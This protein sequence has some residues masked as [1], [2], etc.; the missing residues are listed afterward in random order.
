MVEQS[1]RSLPDA[2]QGRLIGHEFGHALTLG[3]GNGRDDTNDNKVDSLCDS[4]SESDAS[5]HA[6][7]NPKTVMTISRCYAQNETRSTHLE[8]IQ[9]ARAKAAA[10]KI[11]NMV[12]PPDPVPG[13]VISDSRGDAVSDVTQ[14]GLDLVSVTLAQ[15]S[16]TGNTLIAHKMLGDVPVFV[17]NELHDIP[18][19]GRKCSYRRRP[20]D[21]RLR[22]K[23]P[24]CGTDH[25]R[26]SGSMRAASSTVRT[27]R[28]VWKFI[29]GTFSEVSDPNIIASKD[30]M[31]GHDQPAVPPETVWVRIPNSI[32][33]PVTNPMRIQILTDGRESSAN[34]IEQDRLPEA[35]DGRSAPSSFRP[36][37]RRAACRRTRSAP[38]RSRR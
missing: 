22:N 18:R 17:T 23:L 7:A 35:A 8:P 16:Q 27:S 32:R 11:P 10:L 28:R 26:R 1:V 36:S 6:C 15:N 24:R 25:Q 29:R 33:G 34:P 4:T 12:D 13:P 31:L 38:V 30:A 37:T 19:H 14:Q 20:F 3:H 9:I 2:N 5:T 21:S